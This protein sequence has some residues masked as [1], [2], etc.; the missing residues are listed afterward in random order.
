MENNEQ[1]TS[2]C[3]SCKSKNPIKSPSGMIVIG[4]YILISACYGTVTFIKEIIA[5]FAK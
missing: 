2:E 1:Q 3:K 4:S 5:F